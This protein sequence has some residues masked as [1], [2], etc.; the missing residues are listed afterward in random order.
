MLGRVEGAG[1]GEDGGLVLCWGGWRL[2]VMGRMEGWYCVA[3]YS[4]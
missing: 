1:N 4:K 2:Q 3:G